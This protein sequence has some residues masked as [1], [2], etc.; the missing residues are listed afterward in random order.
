MRPESATNEVGSTGPAGLSPLPPA[1]RQ[2]IKMHRQ[3]NEKI[4]KRFFMTVILALI[5]VN[6]NQTQRN[7]D[8]KR[9]R[10]IKFRG[11]VKNDQR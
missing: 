6:I 3:K 8:H 11:S 2:P 4:A 7:T 9:E 5:D 10:L 1:P